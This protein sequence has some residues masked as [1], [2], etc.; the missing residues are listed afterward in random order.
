MSSTLKGET[1]EPELQR[2]GTLPLNEL[3]EEKA[4]KEVEYRINRYLNVSVILNA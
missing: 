3:D 2:A 1:K 4:E